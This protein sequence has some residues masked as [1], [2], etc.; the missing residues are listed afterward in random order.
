[1]PGRQRHGRPRLDSILGCILSEA[2]EV[3]DGIFLA[4]AHALATCVT[5]EQLQKGS[6]YPDQS[7]LRDVS[8]KIACG[9]IRQAQAERVG[10][11]IPDNQIDDLVADSMWYPDYADGVGQGAD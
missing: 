7:Q 3:T 5:D 9:V 4:A 8:R 1:M 10:R 11:M 2:H 6:L